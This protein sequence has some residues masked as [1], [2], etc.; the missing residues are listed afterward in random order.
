MSNEKPKAREI[1]DTIRYTMWA[2]F[3]QVDRLPVDRRALLADA[4]RLLLELEALGVVT[5]QAAHVLARRLLRAALVVR[6]PASTGRV[7]SQPYTGLYAR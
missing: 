5:R 4:E 3:E 2:V 6:W 7:Q 1:N